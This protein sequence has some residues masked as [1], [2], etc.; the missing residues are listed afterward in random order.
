MKPLN[1]SESVVT[2]MQKLLFIDA[3]IRGDASRTRKLAT[4]LVNSLSQRYEVERIDL[5][6]SALLPIDAQQYD[7][8]S[9]EGASPLA[10]DYARKFAAA[11]RIVIAAPFWDMSF[12]SVL[13]VFCEN[14]SLNGITFA[15][16]EDHSTEGLC[17]ATRMLLVT[18]RGMEIEDES[19]LDQATPYL[20]ALGWLWGIPEVQVVS[21]YGMDIHDSSTCAMRLQAAENKGLSLCEEF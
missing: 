14:I 5:T 21:A 1:V 9:R 6:S 10:V 11:D 8:R 4:R 13:K 15:D 12:P 2:G 19:P 17:R 18:T 7:I 16:R 3:C 20:K